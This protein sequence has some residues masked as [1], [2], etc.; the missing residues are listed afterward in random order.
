MT[1]A[2]VYLSWSALLMEY[3]H[4]T[5][6]SPTSILI[7][8]NDRI[9]YANPAFLVFSG[10]K[11]TEIIGQNLFFF[12]DSSDHQEFARFTKCVQMKPR[13]ADRGEFHFITKSGHIRVA[14]VLTTPIIH[15]GEP[16]ILVNLVDISEKQRFEDKIHLDNE[17][18]GNYYYHRS[19]VAHTPPANSWLSQPAHR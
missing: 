6:T 10:Y 7:V 8:R 13:H 9:L 3:R 4:L 12:I 18:P 19:R 16:A 17:T 15:G 1:V 5:E 14:I 11:D 2:D